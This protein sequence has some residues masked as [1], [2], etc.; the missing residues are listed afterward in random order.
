[1][2]WTFS[3]LAPLHQQPPHVPHT[4]WPRDELQSIKSSKRRRT[5]DDT[6]KTVGDQGTGFISGQ[7]VGL[8]LNSIKATKLIYLKDGTHLGACVLK[9]CTLAIV[10]GEHVFVQAHELRPMEAYSQV[11]QMICTFSKIAIASLVEKLSDA[12]KMA[13]QTHKWEMG[14]PRL[15]S[16]TQAGGSLNSIQRI[17]LTITKVT[18]VYLGPL[19][20]VDIASKRGWRGRN[21]YHLPR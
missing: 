3:D 20:R 14:S 17:K 9:N 19:T 16:L 4:A 13:L 7:V 15:A 12:P 5:L 18:T 8:D 11:N 10:V 21:V 1:M 2:S 6:W